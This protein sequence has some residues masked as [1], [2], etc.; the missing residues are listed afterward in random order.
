MI[1]NAGVSED[2]K[3]MTARL[4]DWAFISTPSVEAVGPTIIDITQ[5]AREHGRSVKTA[6]FPFLIWGQSRAE[7]EERLAAIIAEKDGVATANWL[8]DLTAGSGSFD[9]FT[10]DMLAA[11]GGGVH[12][13]GSADDIVEQ[14]I[15]A[16]RLGVNAVM[17]TF[18]EYLADLHRFAK[19][20]QPKLLKAGCI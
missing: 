12:M 3:N 14:L 4:C 19:D 18:P 8:N 10:S 17:L 9:T 16:H 1:A 13:V 7:A 2:A 5:K 15:E 11:S 6:I 20:I